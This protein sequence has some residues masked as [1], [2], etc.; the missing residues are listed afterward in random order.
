MRVQTTG[1]LRTTTSQEIK[2]KNVNSNFTGIYLCLLM[3]QKLSKIL[4]KLYTY[5]NIHLVVLGK[6]FN[7]YCSLC[8]KE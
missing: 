7:K 3:Q 5:F 8:H 2:L 6:L 1:L 4:K